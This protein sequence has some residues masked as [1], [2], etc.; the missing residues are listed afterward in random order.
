MNPD[1]LAVVSA[2]LPASAFEYFPLLFG[3]SAPRPATRCRI[4]ISST[5]NPLANHRQPGQRAVFE[6][7]NRP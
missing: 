6:S 7:T 3:P 4:N 5:T 1:Q 2:P